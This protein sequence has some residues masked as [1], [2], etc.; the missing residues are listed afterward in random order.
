VATVSQALLEGFEVGIEIFC[1]R[2]IDSLTIDFPLG[3]RKLREMKSQIRKLIEA[4]GKRSVIEEFGLTF[5]N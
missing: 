1:I 5:A 4:Y 3:K 2:H